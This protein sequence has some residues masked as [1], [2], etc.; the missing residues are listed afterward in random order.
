MKR[1]E[2]IWGNKQWEARISRWRTIMGGRGEYRNGG[3]EGP[4]RD[5]MRIQA[6]KMGETQN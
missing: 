3:H 1:W 2:V 4:R 5:V 6:W